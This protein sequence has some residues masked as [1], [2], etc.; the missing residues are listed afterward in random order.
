MS[1]DR[2]QLR[3]LITDVNE[4]AGLGAVRSLGRAGHR[5]TLAW[6]EG[7]I[8]PT[9]C[10]SRFGHDQVQYPDPWRQQTRFLEWLTDSVAGKRWDLV[11]PISEAAI[12]ATAR[13][14][15]QLPETVIYAM[16][17]DACLSIA[18]SK[19]HATQLAQRLD[20]PVP[21]TLYLSNGA[22]A[23]TLNP[24]FSGLKFPLI[25]KV[26]NYLDTDDVYVKGYNRIAADADQ[27]RSIL[28]ELSNLRTGI[29]AQELIPGTGYGAFNLRYG[30][31]V[32]LNFAHRRLHEVPWTGGYSSLR[33]SYRN[34]TLLELGQRLIEGANFEG[35]SMAEFRYNPYDT[36]FYFLELNGRFWGSLALAL[37]AGVDFP[38]AYVDCLTN[39]VP[40]LPAPDYPI[41]V[42]CR[43]IF[44]SDIY[45]LSSLFKDQPSQHSLAV[46]TK[47]KMLLGWM[48]I[49]F[50][51]T[52]HHDNF[53]WTDPLPGIVAWR[54]FVV[55]LRLP[56][57]KLRRLLRARRTTRA[58]ATARAE[59]Q[60]RLALP[61]YFSN[62][63]RHILFLCY[64]NICR[65]P[66][67]ELYWNRLLAEHGRLVSVATSA[68]FHPVTQRTT[69]AR[70]L[71]RVA[72]Y[73]LP[74]DEHRSRL[75]T[76]EI[77]D[78]ADAV[79][80]MDFDNL[81]RLRRLSPQS[82]HKTFFLGLFADASDGVIPDPY[83]MNGAQVEI[84]YRLMT[85]AL[86]GLM[87]RLEDDEAAR[88]PEVDS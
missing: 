3:I 70:I 33:A 47:L 41:D 26:D 34:A 4:L 8:Q 83:T 44:P 80:V 45:Y 18:L 38:K 24:D 10:W 49:T 14:R 30:G 54:N 7:D 6:P 72:S 67:A 68:G 27:A 86:D 57:R 43:N 11:L 35:V 37:H 73:K 29:I 50:N 59:H 22:D 51:P 79:F 74:L 16:P 20:I 5:V 13:L 81:R 58:L 42:R 84:V 78:A 71:N 85:R 9:A 31:H 17:P 15:R 32:H 28:R 39:D 61:T 36:R 82:L 76:A 64:G 87:K 1:P 19:Y 53:W 52:I 66:F 88:H 63:P 12:V 23:Q 21:R 25:I 62:P 46:I 48:A 56:A 55:L 69:P 77:I 2:R 75:L 40:L 60:R 65:S